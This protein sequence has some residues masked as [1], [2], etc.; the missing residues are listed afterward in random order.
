MKKKLLIK[1]LACAL[2]C[3]ALLGIAIPVTIQC[4][5]EAAKENFCRNGDYLK[6][7]VY[8]T[9]EYDG[10]CDSDITEWVC[11]YDDRRALVVTNDA[12]AHYFMVKEQQP[13]VFV[14]EEI[15]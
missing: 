8:A 4:R 12:K 3:A 10:Y 9:L 15:S 6:L 11:L 7:W 1:T 13:W 14:W 2:A 5:H